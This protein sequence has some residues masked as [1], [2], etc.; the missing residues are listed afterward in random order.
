MT[1]TDLYKVMDDDIVV[2]IVSTIDYNDDDE[3]LVFIGHPNKIPLE[4]M[5]KM[6]KKI[7]MSSIADIRIRIERS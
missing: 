1:I 7:V 4:L 3:D 5:D 2:S 6:V